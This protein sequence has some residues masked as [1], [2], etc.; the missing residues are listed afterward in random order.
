MLEL[1]L[2]QREYVFPSKQGPL[3]LPSYR[4]AHTS[5]TLPRASFQP[6][7]RHKLPF[8]LT[9]TSEVGAESL[10]ASQR[11][12]LFTWARTPTPA[13]RPQH[14]HPEQVASAG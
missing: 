14:Q 12:Q 11:P 6:L 7:P 8:I 13:A 4:H 3:R 2:W 9:A 1:K 10:S 5:L